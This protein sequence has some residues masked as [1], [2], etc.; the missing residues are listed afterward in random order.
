LDLWEWLAGKDENIPKREWAINPPRFQF[1]MAMIKL[2][3]LPLVRNSNIDRKIS[4]KFDL[5]HDMNE[6]EATKWINK[7]STKIAMK[8]VEAYL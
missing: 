4:L 8:W 2:G 3:K 7:N 6:E 5:P 1:L